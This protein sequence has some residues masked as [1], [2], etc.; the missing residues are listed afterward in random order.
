MKTLN[1]LSTKL[2]FLAFVAFLLTFTACK[3]DDPEPDYPAPSLSISTNDLTLKPGA[4]EDITLTIDAEG[5]LNSIVVNKNGGLLE[6]I[7]LTD[8]DVTSYT[9]TITADNNAD[10]GEVIEY[11][12]IGV[13]TQ[14]E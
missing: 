9:Y 13:N 6:E 7:E 10:E 2:G 11:E 14:D 4:S 8:K 12:F 3:K 5:G 1:Q